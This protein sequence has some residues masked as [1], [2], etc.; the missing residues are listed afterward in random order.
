MHEM[1]QMQML[2]TLETGRLGYCLFSCCDDM[3][4][5]FQ[6]GA[7]VQKF[8]FKS[9]IW[10]L[11]QFPLKGISWWHLAEASLQN[12]VTRVLFSCFVEKPG[13]SSS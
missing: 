12:Y 5:W 6:L 1:T 11:A 8:V 4:L 2:P 7:F 3:S 9:V 10:N 13:E